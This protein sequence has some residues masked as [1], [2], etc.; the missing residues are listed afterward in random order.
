MQYHLLHDVLCK[1]VSPVNFGFFDGG[2]EESEQHVLKMGQ[3]HW[4]IPSY[5]YSGV[6][7]NQ[8]F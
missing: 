3:L 2:V 5:Q 4:K 8:S 6:T 7:A 1:P